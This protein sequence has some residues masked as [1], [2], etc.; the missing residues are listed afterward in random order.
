VWRL[1]A[2]RSS[3]SAQASIVQLRRDAGGLVAFSDVGTFI[4]PKVMILGAA[5]GVLRSDD[6]IGSQVTTIEKRISDAQA[7]GKTV[8]AAQA[9]LSDLKAQLTQSS[10]VAQGLLASVPTITADRLAEIGAGQT[11][12]AGAKSAVA[13][14]QSDISKI[15]AALQS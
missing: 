7:R 9:A 6:T 10:G 12:L 13:A 3:I 1:T 4:V 8:Y 2:L 5:D 15:D 14:A 11:L